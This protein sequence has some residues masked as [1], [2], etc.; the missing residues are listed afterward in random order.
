MYYASKQ[1]IQEHS[2]QK[3]EGLGVPSVVKFKGRFR[4]A[5]TATWPTKLA[6]TDLVSSLDDL[7]IG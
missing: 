7:Y 1:L 3:S 4:N 5:G 2:F 6:I